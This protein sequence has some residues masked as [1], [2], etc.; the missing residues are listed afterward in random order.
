MAKQS[1]AHS[2]RINGKEVEV[3]I[4]SHPASR[5]LSLRLITGENAVKVVSPPGYP[6]R[7]ILDFVSRQHDWIARRLEQNP[8]IPP[9]HHGMT[10]PIL[11]KDHRIIRI[12]PGTAAN[13]NKGAAWL[14]AE[15]LFI[16]SHEEHLPRRVSDF[17]KGE[18]RYEITLR[19]R[20]KSAKIEKKIAG[21]RIKDTTSRWGS[22]SSSGN[23]NFSWRLI[24]TPEAVLDYVVAHEVAHLVHM[25]HSPD[26]WR[27][28]DQLTSSRKTSQR[29]LKQH[30]SRLLT[31]G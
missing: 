5:K 11:G 13:K 3:R 2:T 27:L 31:Y 30:G 9:Y 29:W 20:E 7:E 18:V 15:Q 23:L 6:L 26:F 10:I 21:I 17:L 4:Q 1:S 12:E 24:F 16:K 25:N 22:C 8:E 28:V 14:E 19:A